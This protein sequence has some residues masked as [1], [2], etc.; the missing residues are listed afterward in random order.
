MPD[1]AAVEMGRTGPALSATSDAPSHDRPAPAV[2]AVAGKG[3][4]DVALVTKKVEPVKVE[5][6]AENAKVD[7]PEG[8][9][10]TDPPE[11][12]DNADHGDEATERGEDG[13]FKAKEKTPEA[14]EK[15]EKGI[16]KDTIKE[17]KKRQA[18]EERAETAETQLAQALTALEELG[19]KTKADT[20]AAVEASPKP[21]RE[22]F[23]DPDTYEAA[24]I[25]W[26]TET[27]TKAMEARREQERSTET[28]QQEQERQQKEQQKATEA[29]QKSWKG[30]REAALEKYPDYEEVAESDEVQITAP[31][32]FAIMNADN[33]PD[34]AYFLGKNPKEAERIAALPAL[35]QQLEIGRLSLKLETEE[36]R[37]VTKAPPPATPL[38]SR[39]K[40]AEKSPDE[41][42]MEEYAARRQ[43]E[44]AQRRS[45]TRPS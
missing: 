43:R 32:A 16:L 38:R 27:T 17:R 37:S 12:G 6:T 30:A 7:P 4:P 15:A 39:E 24:L 41:E 36:K 19:K 40:A 20:K 2:S 14:D 5:K 33:G 23:Q 29:L 42:S 26:T 13:K 8:E 21:K 22:D 11:G 1:P 9:V 44:E 10:K 3:N 31:A 45:K 25:T 35:K 34:I 18:A 28:A